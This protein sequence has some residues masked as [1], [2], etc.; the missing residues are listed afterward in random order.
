M[1]ALPQNH[2]L[3]DVG[4]EEPSEAKR[5]E[6]EQSARVVSEFVS[7]IEQRGYAPGERLPSERDLA[8]R[9]SVG[10]GVIREALTTLEVMRYLERKPNSGIFLCR[11]PDATSLEALVLFSDLGLPVDRAVVAQCLEVRRLIEVQ[12]VLLACRRRTDDDLRALRITLNEF[13]VY[14]GDFCRCG[15]LL[16]SLD[17]QFHM[18]IVRATHNEIFVRLVTPF[19]VMYRKRRATFFE[20]KS[21]CAESHRQ[22]EQIFGA[23]KSRKGRKAQELLGAHIGR[24]ERFFASQAKLAGFGT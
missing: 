18:D 6:R 8:E 16:P 15:E 20:D 3:S 5:T 12:A 23:L 14:L 9:F 2:Q 10:R 17:F 19:Y 24:V 1:I 4:R 21:R 7:L 13:A 11:R 22:H